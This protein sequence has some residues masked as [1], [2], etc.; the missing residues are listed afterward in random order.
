MTIAI[1]ARRYEQQFEADGDNF[2][3]LFTSPA[4]KIEKKT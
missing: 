2:P 1:D 4:S 3:H